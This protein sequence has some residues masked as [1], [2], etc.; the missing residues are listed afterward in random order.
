MTI[1]NDSN[2]V[3]VSYDDSGVHMCFEGDYVSTPDHEPGKTDE[4]EIENALVAEVSGITSHIEFLERHT[5]ILFVID[6]VS[7]YGK[8]EPKQAYIKFLQQHLKNI[9]ANPADYF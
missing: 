4:E 6:C 8:P 9:N 3:K 5:N 1:S 7:R 2:T